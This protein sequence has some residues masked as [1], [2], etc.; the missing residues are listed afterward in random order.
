M[1]TFELFLVMQYDVGMSEPNN[2]NSAGKFMKSHK[3][4]VA[5]Y[6][7]MRLLSKIQDNF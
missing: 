3:G 6:M 7:I 2:K 4:S 5:W 1:E